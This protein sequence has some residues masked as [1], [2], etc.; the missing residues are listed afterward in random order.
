MNDREKSDAAKA[1]AKAGDMA[2][3]EVLYRELWSSENKNVWDARGLINALRK[4]DR[5]EDAI[6]VGRE[7]LEIDPRFDPVLGELSWAIWQ[8]A[9]KP[10]EGRVNDAVVEEVVRLREASQDPYSQYAAFTRCLLDIAKRD[11]EHNDAARADRLTALLDAARLDGATNRFD[12][13]T[14]PGDRQRLYT[15]RGKALKAM[16][17]WQDLERHGNAVA[18]DTSIRWANDGDVWIER[19]RIESIF[20]LG[21]IEEAFE[22]TTALLKRFDEWYVHADLARYL[23]LL[24]RK[25]EALVEIL[26]AANGQGPFD[27]KVNAFKLLAGL[28]E[29]MGRPELAGPFAQATISIRSDK[30]WPADVEVA[31]ICDRIGWTPSDAN[32]R[33]VQRDVGEALAALVN[34][35]DPPLRGEVK[36]VLPNGKS[37][38]I[39]DENG[40]DRFF[41]AREVT[42][43]SGRLTVGLRV[44]FRPTKSFDKKKNR[45]SDAAAD[46]RIAD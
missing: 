32:L 13:K 2:K 22:A 27:F 24:D 9:V 33:A 45:E 6:T 19:W 40:V 44:T 35:M 46:V 7:A 29:A 14:L 15:L 39:V 25:D 3:A 21:R 10:E 12:G 34:E 30:G 18:M 11:L 26:K 42:F 20:Q 5:F 8:S 4:Q 17:K 36:V 37:G 43:P 23:Y 1:A 28:L 41:G 16:S 38:F 31:A